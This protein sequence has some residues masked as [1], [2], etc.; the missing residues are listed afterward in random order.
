MLKPVLC[1]VLIRT[2]T[3]PS[4]SSLIFFNTF[5]DLMRNIISFLLKADAFCVSTE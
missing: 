4:R 5:G 2:Q 1:C 3:A